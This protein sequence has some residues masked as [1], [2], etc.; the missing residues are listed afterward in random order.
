MAV[1]PR[2]SRQITPAP[3]SLWGGN[4]EE[5][6]GSIQP[7]QS[8]L[9]GSSGIR[10]RLRRS[11]ER[12]GRRWH[13]EKSQAAEDNRPRRT[14]RIL[15]V[16]SALHRA[17]EDFEVQFFL[18]TGLSTLSTS[19]GNL[20]PAGE[21]LRI[22]FLI[23]GSSYSEQHGGEMARSSTPAIVATRCMGGRLQVS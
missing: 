14:S 11:Q 9:L 16:S 17:L 7:W 22:C 23:L 20:S 10:P 21:C 6:K 12:Q 15:A 13:L 4:T 8:S 1:D 18:V 19:T 2:G 3:T 5:E